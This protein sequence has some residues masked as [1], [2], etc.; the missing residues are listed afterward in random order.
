M[1]TEIAIAALTQGL[2]HFQ[3]IHDVNDKVMIDVLTEC[4]EMYKRKILAKN[5]MAKKDNQ[6]VPSDPVT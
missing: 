3:S 2:K 4:A 5:L 6:K 1:N